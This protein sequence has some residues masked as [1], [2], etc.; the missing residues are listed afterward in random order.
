[1]K[2]KLQRELLRGGV[3]QEHVQQL[4]VL[5][6]DGAFHQVL[7][8]GVHAGPDAGVLRH[9]LLGLDIDVVSHLDG[10]QERRRNQRRSTFRGRA[11]G[12]QVPAR[13]QT[14][15]STRLSGL[16]GPR[17]QTLRPPLVD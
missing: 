11:E 5:Q 3:T 2:P 7:E 10:Q 16:A 1:M 15:S 8:V 6:Q 4:L 9:P 13:C 12:G 17:S 14:W